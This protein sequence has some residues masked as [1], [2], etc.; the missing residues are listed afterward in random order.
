MPKRGM[1]EGAEKLAHYIGHR[2]RLRERF[3]EGADALPDYELLELA[4]FAV[5][6]REDVK[7]RAKAILKEFGGDLTALFAAPRERLRL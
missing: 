1:A 2:E 4:L 7:E 3:R 5:I 6:P